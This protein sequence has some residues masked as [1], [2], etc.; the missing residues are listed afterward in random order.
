MFFRKRRIYLDYA[1]ATPLCDDARDAMRE[2]EKACG[3]PSSIHREGVE[4]K[5][6][7]QKSRAHIAA[8]LG[9]KPRDLIFTSGI[10]EAN[11]L[12]I[13]GL[14]RQ[15]EIEKKF[16]GSHWVVSSIEHASVLAS[17]IE[18]ERRGGMVSRLEPDEKGII[19]AESV[20]A[21]LRQETV[22]VS[23]GWANN[24]I[25]TIQ[26]LSEISAAIA[27]HEKNARTHVIFHSDA[28]QGPLYLFPQVHSLGVDLFSFGSSKLYGPH[29]IG[30]L[31]VSSRT[32]IAPIIFG[33]G[34]ERGLRSGTESVALAAG[35]AAAVSCV[36]RERAQES[37]RLSGLRDSLANALSRAIPEIVV[38]GDL[39]RALPHMLNVSIPHTN[40]EYF[41]LA[42][43]RAGVAVST[44]SACAEGEESESHVVRALV[45]AA[46]DSPPAG[47]WR[48][49][50]S[51]RFSLGR[52]TTKEDIR[53]CIEAVKKAVIAA[54][55]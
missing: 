14:A 19:H 11:N 40:S 46:G 37:R 48:A 1:S 42:L 7:L 53:Q 8:D 54:S 29:G 35:F 52:N 26:P 27:A 9:C 16:A 44:K 13:L 50:A 17:F 51:V 28:G 10:T 6:S 2:A 39:K 34:Q 47:G 25:G 45:R 31:Y 5:Q 4:A 15:L 49:Q 18:I 24:E 20:T 22:C 38:N 3:N 43:D 33:G 36:A 32:K 23:A 41:L 30:A 12:A 55:V 21:N